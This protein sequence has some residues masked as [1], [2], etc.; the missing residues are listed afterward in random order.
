MGGNHTDGV[1]RP[2]C[3][4]PTTGDLRTNT[5]EGKKFVEDELH[6]PNVKGPVKNYISIGYDVKNTIDTVHSYVLEPIRQRTNKKTI[7]KRRH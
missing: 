5:A 4:G 2:S 3:S 1:H 7:C 6:V